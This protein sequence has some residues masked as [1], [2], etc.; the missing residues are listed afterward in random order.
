MLALFLSIG[1]VCALLLVLGVAMR[2]KASS[3]ANLRLREVDL[4]AFRNLLSPSDDQF[5]KHSLSARHY[6]QV[7]RARLR[8][9][10]EYLGWIA[11]NCAVL[12]RLLRSTED[13]SNIDA[14]HDIPVLGQSIVRLRLIAVA[15]WLLL[16]V[17]YLLPNLQIRPL[18]TIRKYEDLWRTAEIHLER[19]VPQSTVVADHHPA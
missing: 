16:W 18:H 5:L 13:R 8:A 2:S 15:F 12:L 6:R 10:Q 11:G 14:A 7:R 19:I 1:G 17:E 4:A 3:E 9:T